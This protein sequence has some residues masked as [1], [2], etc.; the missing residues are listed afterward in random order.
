MRVVK[1]GTGA[2]LQR[3]D[4]YP[5]GSVSGSWASS[6]NPSQPTLRYRFS[7]KEIAGQIVDASLV[8]SALAGTPAAAAGTPYL[9]FGARLYDPRS[10]AWLSQDPLAKKYYH[11]SPYVYCAGNPVNITDLDGRVLLFAPGV[12]DEFIRRFTEAIQIMNEFNISYNFAK[13]EES[14]YIYYISESANGSAFSWNYD[15]ESGFRTGV[16]YWDD[17]AIAEGDDGI[18]SSS[19]TQLAHEV[20]H[21]VGFDLNPLEYEKRT[22]QEVIGYDN[23][24]EYRVITTA[25]QYAARNLGEIRRD[26]ITRTNHGSVIYHITRSTS[27]KEMIQYVISHNTHR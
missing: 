22:K 10:A 18:Y 11:I 9:D 2:V 17:I 26:E 24:E 5:F 6:T 12:S 19:I 4:Y 21:A 20:S 3:F 16:I 27:L 25:E 7:G 8:A 1:D 15:K 14:E 13:L 23:R